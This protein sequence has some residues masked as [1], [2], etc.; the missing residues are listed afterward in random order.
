MKVS[1]VVWMEMVWLVFC[2]GGE[3]RELK[4]SVERRRKRVEEGLT[5]LDNNIYN[6]RK[7]MDHGMFIVRDFDFLVLGLGFETR[8]NWMREAVSNY[9]STPFFQRPMY[10]AWPIFILP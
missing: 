1:L 10:S 9:S 2:S 5:M 6:E 7:G 8:L 4:T 3:E